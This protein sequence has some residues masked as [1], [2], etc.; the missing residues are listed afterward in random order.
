M[1]GSASGSG[2]GLFLPDQHIMR[3]I[4]DFMENETAS[5]MAEKIDQDKKLTQEQ[6]D[7]LISNIMGLQQH[8]GG[9]AKDYTEAGSATGL[10][11]GALLSYLMLRD[12]NIKSPWIKALLGGA[13]MTASGVA[14]GLV[15]KNL[16]TGFKVTKP[17]PIRYSKW[18]GLRYE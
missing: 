18:K 7:K 13:I 11:G 5:S 15:G 14:G 12:S 10:V 9:M 6:K 17:A 4:Q 1:S 16:G 8:Y 3:K 2:K